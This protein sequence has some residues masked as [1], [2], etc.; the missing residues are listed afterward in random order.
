M[1]PSVFIANV[2]C[3]AS[4]ENDICEASGITTY[5]TLHYYLDGAEHDYTGPM[6]LEALHEF[7]DST[8]VVPCNPILDTTTC[9]ERAKKYAGKWMDKDATAIRSEIERL[10]RMMEDAGA[11]TAAELR[12]WMRERRDILQILHEDKRAKEETEQSEL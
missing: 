5:P 4:A 11:S 1:H 8:L 3:G 12:R 2:D 9:T 7:V 6:S 10:G